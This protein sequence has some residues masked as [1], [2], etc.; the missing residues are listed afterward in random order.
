MRAAIGRTLADRLTRTNA[1]PLP[2]CSIEKSAHFAPPANANPGLP[3]ARRIPACTFVDAIAPQ[4]GDLLSNARDPLARPWRRFAGFSAHTAFETRINASRVSLA[5]P[6]LST[7]RAR[8]TPS[9]REAA[10]PA[11]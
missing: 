11:A 1:M 10:T 3:L 2:V 6:L 8:A 5:L 9:H 7:S 4:A